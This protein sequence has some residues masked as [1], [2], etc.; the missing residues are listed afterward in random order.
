MSVILKTDLGT[1]TY[2][3]DYIATLVGIA[4]TECYGVVG[5]V[6]QSMSDGFNG[7]LK[8]DNYKKGVKIS[9]KEDNSINIQLFISVQYGISIIA[10][11]N[12]IIS[13]VSYQIEK[14]TGLKVNKVDVVVGDIQVH[15]D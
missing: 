9:T 1:I 10:I 2:T 3:D 11:V 8:R 5:M 14:L 15:A 13:T 12:S 4:A 6:S 7:I